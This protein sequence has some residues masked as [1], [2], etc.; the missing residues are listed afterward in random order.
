M[1][2]GMTNM[3]AASMI[4]TRRPATGRPAPTALIFPPSTRMSAWSK[5][6]VRAAVRMVALRIRTRPLVSRL[7]DAVGVQFGVLLAFAADFALL[8]LRLGLFGLRLSFLGVS[9]GCLGVFLLA[10]SAALSFWPRFVTWC[11]FEVELDAVGEN[12]WPWSS[13]Q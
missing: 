9:L 1:M 12:T 3:P 5:P 10:E 2:P 11:A 6:A 7:R 4:G 8:R 13:R